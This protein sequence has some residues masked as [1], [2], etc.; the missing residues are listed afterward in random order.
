MDTSTHVHAI[1]EDLRAAA[2]DA[3]EEVVERIVRST[4]S[5]LHLRL[6]DALGEAA[7]DLSE[8]IPGGNVEVRLAGRDAR[9]VFVPD[10]EATRP[11]ID[12]ADEADRGTARLTLRM[13]ERLKRRVESAADGEGVST[14]A[15][16]VDAVVRRLEHRPSRRSGRRVVGYARG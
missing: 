6:L 7:L 5:S 11:T 12:D 3:N 8:T 2:D 16:L 4:E 9:F 14:N 15:W 1:A 13:P 10:A